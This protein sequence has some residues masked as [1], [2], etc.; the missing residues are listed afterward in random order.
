ME[1]AD[2]PAGRIVFRIGNKG[3]RCR[4]GKEEDEMKKTQLF[5][6]LLAAALLAGT[7]L[8]T[9]A[10]ADEGHR[11]GLT[12]APNPVI[13][14]RPQMEVTRAQA[15]ARL[16]ALS[17]K[18]QVN[19]LIPFGD[20]AE[21]TEEAEAIRWAAAEGIVSGYTA[22]CFGP[23]DPVTREQLSAMIYHLVQKFDLGFRGAWMFHLGCKDLDQLRDW[24]FEPMYW[25]VAS[26]L[27]DGNAEEL[28]PRAFV[29]AE[30]AD[31][32]FAGL[33]QIGTDK[34]IDFQA[35]FSNN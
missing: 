23:Q 29:T 1:S 5:C 20:V 7:A 28:K 31:A 35:G 6:G 22:D 14:P 3:R 33:A 13:A 27:L 21:G 26:R 30:E 32:I 11:G 34:G 18:P 25:M 24:G 4:S 2:D 16:W 8:P 19:A 12:I 10:L 17:G 9:A 15:V